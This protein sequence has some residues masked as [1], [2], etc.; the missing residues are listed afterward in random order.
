MRVVANNAWLSSLN[1]NLNRRLID[2]R[3]KDGSYNF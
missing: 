3:A 1:N 2:L